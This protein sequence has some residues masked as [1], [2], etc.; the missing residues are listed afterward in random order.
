MA[1][2]VPATAA[3]SRK[4]SPGTWGLGEEPAGMAFLEAASGPLGEWS[5]EDLRFSETTKKS[6]KVC[7]Q[8]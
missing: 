6:P 4:E 3:A 1:A 2:A 8:E 5:V 7:G